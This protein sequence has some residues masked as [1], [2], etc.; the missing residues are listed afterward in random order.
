M[1]NQWLGATTSLKSHRISTVFLCLNVSESSVVFLKETRS[2][3]ARLNFLS[4]WKVRIVSLLSSCAS[5]RKW[6][7]IS[8]ISPVFLYHCFL[9]PSWRASL[10]QT[11][12]QIIASYSLVFKGLVSDPFVRPLV[13]KTIHNIVTK[14]HSQLAP[15]VRVCLRTLR[16][17]KLLTLVKRYK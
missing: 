17:N 14:V 11:E 2:R 12:S 6:F 3:S 8:K 10:V 7:T 9:Q 13:L 5:A 4:I 1:N 15:N 16:R